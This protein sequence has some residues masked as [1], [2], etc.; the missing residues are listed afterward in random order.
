MYSAVKSDEFDD[1]LDLKVNPFLQIIWPFRFS[2][3]SII[4]D[5]S[6]AEILLG[7]AMLTTV[8]IKRF[9]AI[10]Q[11]QS[12]P[13]RTLWLQ[14]LETWRRTGMLR[15]IYNRTYQNPDDDESS[16]AS[17]ETEQD[18]HSGSSNSST[19][20]FITEKAVEARQRIKRRR[21]TKEPTDT[22]TSKRQKQGNF[23]S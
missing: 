5:S 18:D 19:D 9:K 17:L 21:P 22:P 20:E 3:E 12:I 11:Q 15:A 13:H 6:D 1:A 10:L 23:E 14:N 4:L 16:E 2:P 8:G 7:M